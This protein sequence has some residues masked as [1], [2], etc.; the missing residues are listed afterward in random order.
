LPAALGIDELLESAGRDL[1]CT[2]WRRVEPSQLAD[3]AAATAAPVPAPGDAAP[4][5]FVLALTN[6]FLPQLL[7]VHD[8][9]NGVNYGA[10]E[11]RFPAAVQ[12]GDR[13]R[14]C[15]RVLGATETAGGV[16]TTIE[17]RVDVEGGGAPAC[18]VQSLSR[19]LR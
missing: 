15:A 5:L 7:L 6:L 9:A 14:A 11:I 12:A 19:W 8:A 2:E 4:P 3:F 18:V 10:G 13:L 16:Q 17:I 1:G